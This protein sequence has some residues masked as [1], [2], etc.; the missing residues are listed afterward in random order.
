MADGSIA[1]RYAKAL[2]AL[3]QEEG[4]ITDALTQE[5]EAAVAAL[6]ANNGQLLEALSHPALSL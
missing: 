6:Q 1:R 5:L 3:G 4:G 2:V